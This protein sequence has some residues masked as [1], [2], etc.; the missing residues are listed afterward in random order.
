MRLFSSSVVLSILV[1]IAATAAF[2]SDY[3]PGEIIVKYKPNSVRTRLGM[4]SLYMAAGVMKVR[5]FAG[6]EHLFL[7]DDIKVEDAIATLKK[8]PDVEYAEPN[9]IVRL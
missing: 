3:R 1:G 9:Y 6:V 2:G 8:N 4:N 5:R 7:A